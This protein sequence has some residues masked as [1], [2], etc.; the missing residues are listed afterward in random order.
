MLA[1]NWKILTQNPSALFYLKLKIFGRRP[2]SF[3]SH[4]YLSECTAHTYVPRRYWHNLQPSHSTPHPCLQSILPR[5]AI[6]FFLSAYAPVRCW[7]PFAEAVATDLTSW[8]V[9]VRQARARVSSMVI[10]VRVC[11]MWQTRDTKWNTRTACCVGT[12]PLDHIDLACQW[13]LLWAMEA[14]KRHPSCQSYAMLFWMI[15]HRT[16][17]CYTENSQ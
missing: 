9:T 8:I 2:E 3:G 7:C 12:R 1:Y 11:I 13:T 6:D 14:R 16:R 4:T 17:V 10:I 5:S 15:W